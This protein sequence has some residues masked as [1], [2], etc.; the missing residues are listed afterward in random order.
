MHHDTHV[1]LKMILSGFYLYKNIDDKVPKGMHN[2]S[3]VFLKEKDQVYLDDKK[4]YKCLISSIY[5]HI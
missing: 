2:L 4:F 5:D 1:V 3:G